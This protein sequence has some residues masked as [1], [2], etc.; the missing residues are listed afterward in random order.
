MKNRLLY[1][2]LDYLLPIV[3]FVLLIAYAVFDV[4]TNA[5]AGNADL[6]RGRVY[7]VI[8]SI[9]AF[10]LLYVLFHNP[11]F[12]LRLPSIPALILIL[13][14]LIIDNLINHSFSRAAQINIMLC[15]L[16]IVTYYSFFQATKQAHANQLFDLF[17]I[18][19][20]FVYCA[21]NIYA[22][23]N[24]AIANDREFGMTSYSYYLLSFLPA[25][26]LIKRKGIRAGLLI[27]CSLFVLISL[28]R[29]PI[30]AL[31]IIMLVYWYS[32]AKVGLSR[33]KAFRA[34]LIV[35]F[36]YLAILSINYFTKGFLLDRFSNQ[37]L[38]SASGRDQMWSIIWSQ[39]QS[40]DLLTL[41]YGMGSGAS[42]KLLGT[43][44]HN[45]WLEFLFT[46]GIIGVILYFVLFVSLLKRYSRL[47][48]LRS[49]FAP[50]YGSAVAFFFLSGLSDGFFFVYWSF[51]FFAILG[52][53]EGLILRQNYS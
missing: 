2:P 8:V 53:I 49:V 3:L 48:R 21:V 4:T 27:I 31:P 38:S 16:W 32:K 5:Q 19:L 30:L 34:I 40:R 29:G 12:A 46:F 43:G 22:Q 47:I 14:W 10:L 15:V 33:I 13:S 52:Y 1:Y 51:Y 9:L 36:A 39:I 11:L 42:V 7:V 28:K 37:Q 45:E 17:F 23:R 18:C 25:I 20:F 50:Q 44:V 6:S 24:I 41:L 35:V 26:L